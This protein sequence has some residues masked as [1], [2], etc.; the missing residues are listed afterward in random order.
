MAFAATNTSSPT[1]RSSSI[2]RSSN[3]RSSWRPC[4]SA[5]PGPEQRRLC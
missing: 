4:R 3:S 2:R 1:R 5:S